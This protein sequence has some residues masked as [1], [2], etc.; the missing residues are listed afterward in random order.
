MRTRGWAVLNTLR[1]NELRLIFNFSKY[2]VI[3]VIVYI[4]N[5]LKLYNVKV[6][7]DFI[8]AD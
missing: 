8:L 3:R 4:V 2:V 5:V 1:S 7:S 6:A